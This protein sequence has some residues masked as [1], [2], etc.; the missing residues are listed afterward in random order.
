MGTQRP[1][2]QSRPLRVF[3]ANVGKN[4][5]AYDCALALAHKERYD[6]AL[7]QEPWTVVK[8]GC[9][10]IKTHM[11]FDIFSSVREWKDNDTRPRVLIYALRQN[12]LT[13]DLAFSNVPLAETT[14]EDHLATSSDHYTL[15]T[16]LPCSQPAPV[17]PSKFRINTEDDVKRFSDFI[18]LG[19]PSLP[20]FTEEQASLDN[21]AT[22]L[23][24]LLHTAIT[25]IGRPL[26]KAAKAAPWWTEECERLHTYYTALRRTAFNE[27]DE[28]L[29]EAKRDFRRLIE[30]EKKGYWRHVIDDI[31]NQQE[32]FGLTKWARPAS[33][34][35]FPPLQIGDEVYETQL[36]K[37][38]ALRRA[39]L[40]RRSEAD[41]IADAWI[42]LPAKSPLPLSNSVSL[43]DAEEATTRAGN[44][45][46]GSDLIMI[47][48]IQAAWPYVGEYIRRLFEFCLCAGHH[49]TVFKNAEVVMLAKPGK[50]DLT[51]ARAWRPISLLSCIGKGLER[52]IARRI[53]HIA[54]TMHILHPL[55]AGALPKRSAVDLVAHL[56]HDIESA[57]LC[58]KVATLVTMDIQGAFDTV[59]RNRL[60]LRLRE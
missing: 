16:T 55:Q 4:G 11:A 28:A 41:D 48:L 56:V 21:A 43:R 51:T 58:G 35:Q 60:V 23:I 45:S 13:I 44:T 38:L 9:S 18:R 32:I 22:C 6:I 17:P 24:D 52:L 3:Q 30:Y 36:T 15:S 14:V 54:V 37:A 57:L 12:N 10:L 46:P 53:A 50:R 20:E 59:M 42:P 31:R 7:L 40:E 47:A 2:A 5:A 19:T 26:R 27:Q 49:P 34:F 39:T 33:P 29:A 25:T 8:E 1:H